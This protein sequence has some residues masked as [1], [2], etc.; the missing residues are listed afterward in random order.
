M[1]Y[2][3]FSVTQNLIDL[4]YGVQQKDDLMAKR[5]K[6]LFVLTPLPE[7]R[8]KVPKPS[9]YIGRR[10]PLGDV[11]RIDGNGEENMAIVAQNPHH[12]NTILEFSTPWTPLA[13][14]HFD[15]RPR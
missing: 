9:N 7:K 13:I 1:A 10:I 11:R 14:H 5:V 15:Q 3:K 6:S 12:Y 4:F 2:V 8:Y